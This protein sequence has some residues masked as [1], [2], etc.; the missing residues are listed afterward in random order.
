VLLGTDQVLGINPALSGPA[1]FTLTPGPVTLSGAGVKPDYA[2]VGPSIGAAWTTRDGKTVIRGGFRIGYDDLF[3]NIPINQTS[4][5][6]FSLT[7]TQ[8][9]GVT[10]PGTYSWNLAFNQISERT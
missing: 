3:N 7:T 10:Q 9:A 6:P 4:N 8:T 1:A 5:S 2:D